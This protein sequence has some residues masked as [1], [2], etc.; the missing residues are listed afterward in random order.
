VFEIGY[1]GSRGTRLRVVTPMNA[2]PR[3]Y[4]STSQ[5][6]DQAM[7]D[8]LSARVANPFINIPG[9]AGTAFFSGV[10]TTRSQLLRAYPQFG[11]LS[12]DLPAGSSWYYAMTARFERRFQAG[13]QFQANYTWSKTMEA[14]NYLN[15]TDVAP[16]HVVSV[17]DRPHR[18]TFSGLYELPF[19]RNKKWLAG[20]HPILNRI[21]GGWQIQAIHQRQS[22][23]GLA[24]GNVLVRGS[25]DQ[26]AVSDQ[27][28]DRWFNTD[29][30]ERRANAQ[31]ENNIRALSS[32]TGAVRAG[33][34]NVWDI[35]AH[36]NFV[37]RERLTVQL[38]GEAE[39][40]TNT[41]NFAAPNLNPTSTL[42]GRVTNTQTGQEERRIFVG[43]KLIF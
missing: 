41:P 26:L 21:I 6:R 36:K 27:H 42:F 13:L 28:I 5:E 16:E 35:S 24:F 29:L 9:F 14:V 8:F 18:V 39:G 11:G 17:I 4:Q 7:I 15:E 34:I 40:A 10:N 30:F 1:I 25:F 22:G 20:A 3:D 2:T 38:R 33:G 32:R 23:P 12:T 31:L 19:G 37:I 43:L